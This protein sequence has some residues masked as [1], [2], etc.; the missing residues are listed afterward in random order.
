M[1]AKHAFPSVRRLSTGGDYK[2]V[3]AAPDLKA[4]EKQV[5]LLARRN[6]APQH[7]LGL[8]VAKK[9]ISTAV[10]RNLVKRLSREAFRDMQDFEPHLD[11]VVLSRP[12]AGSADRRELR[13]ALRRQFA[14]L[15]QRAARLS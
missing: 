1:T 7:R 14:R 15:E 9:H 10:K 2:R 3:F 6:S 12:A 11:I 5:L 13:E 4:G 8:A